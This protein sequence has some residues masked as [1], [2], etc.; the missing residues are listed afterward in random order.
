MNATKLLA[1]SHHHETLAND[2][3]CDVSSTRIAFVRVKDAP[4]NT[5]HHVLPQRFEVGDHTIIYE[6]DR[7]FHFFLRGHLRLSDTIEIQRLVFDYGDRYGSFAFLVDVTKMAGLDPAARK[8]WAGPSRS[9]P[10]E[11]AYLYG[12]SFATRTLILSVYRAG[13]LLLP[14]FFTWAIKMPPDEESARQEIAK[15]RASTKNT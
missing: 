8:L 9:Y 4:V 15:D 12:S 10:F 1:N 6:P 5:S 13:K 11:V 14:H 2:P 7:V 3:L